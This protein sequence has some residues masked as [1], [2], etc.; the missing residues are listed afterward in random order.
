M[1]PIADGYFSYLQGM[2]LICAP[3][4]HCMPG[5]F[6]AGSFSIAATLNSIAEVDAFYA[7]SVII[8]RKIPLY[9]VCGHIGAQAGSKARTRAQAK[10]G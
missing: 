5:K 8:T 9:Y 7:F 3:L 2:N 6:G 1:V 10:C 4:L